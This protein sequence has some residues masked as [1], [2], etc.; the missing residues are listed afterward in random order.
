MQLEDPQVANPTIAH[1]IED[2]R[3]RIAN[4]APYSFVKL[5]HHGSDN[6]FSESLLNELGGSRTFGIC[7]GENSTKHPHRET[8]A[9]LDDHQPAL[10]WVRTDHNGLVSIDLSGAKPKFEPTRGKLNDPRPNAV[11]PQLMSQVSTRSAP[12]PSSAPEVTVTSQSAGDDIVEV[13]TRIPHVTTS[14]TVSIDVQP[15]AAPAAAIR[16]RDTMTSAQLAGGRDLPRLLFVTQPEALARNI[17]QVEAKQVIDMLRASDHTVCESLSAGSDLDPALTAVRA[18]LRNAHDVKGVVLVGG[19][20]VVPSGRVDCLP[21]RLRS[22]L[23]GG[24]DPDDF[25]VWSDDCYGDTDGDNLAELPVSRIPDGKSAE[26]VIAALGAPNRGGRPV[27]R[28]GVRNVA[29]PFADGIF[30]SINGPESLLV[31]DPVTFRDHGHLDGDHIYL[32]LHGDF[33]DGSRFWG[34]DTP[35]GLEAVN[36][37]NV[38]EEA[39]AVVFTGCCWGALTVDTPAN[40]VTP[41]RPYG[42]KTPEASV[43]LSF[44]RAGATGFVGCTGAH[45]SPIDAPYDYYG[46]PMHAAFWSNYQ[47]GLPPAAAL[48]EAKRTYAGEIPHRSGAGN[49]AIELKIFRQYTC[50]GLGW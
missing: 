33:V 8:L 28:R 21:P 41:G 49:E 31:S 7:A 47:S 9:L 22:Q 13:V 35:N 20:D 24:G 11:D 45:Y 27:A 14:V 46:G 36:V 18:I 40:R 10:T 17:G 48:F 34:E 23:G 2:L 25:V 32:M 29:R 1:E 5:S 26:L 44:L 19:Y 30:G 42:Q 37:S 12:T 38:P 15:E 50:L 6:A 43:A 16:M 4:D 3:A 39:G